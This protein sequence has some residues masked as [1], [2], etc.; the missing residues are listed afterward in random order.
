LIKFAEVSGVL[1]MDKKFNIS[2]I[3]VE[4]MKWDRDINGLSLALKSDNDYIRKEAAEALRY[5]PGKKTIKSLLDM[6]D[7]KFWA[8]RAVSIQSLAYI[9]EKDLIPH[10]SDYLKDDSWVVRCSTIEAL[11]ELG[12]KEVTDQI[13]PFLF[14]EDDH[15]RDTIERSLNKL[16]DKESPISET[17]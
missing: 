15:V 17:Y 8:V 3:D 11:V 13:L 7:D 1:L 4:N 16:K 10:I 12:G 9:G 5:I 6:L 14:D 2:L